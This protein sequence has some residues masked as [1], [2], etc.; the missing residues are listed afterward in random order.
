METAGLVIGVAGLAGLFTS[1]VEA[2]DKI[3]SYRTFGTDSHVLNTR[4][5][6]ARAR[7]E[8]W[9][10]GVGI[11][12]GRLKH[13]HHPALD[14]KAVSDAV[15]ELLHIIP[16]NRLGDTSGRVE[17]EKW[18]EFYGFWH[19]IVDSPTE[20]I[21]RERLAK[22]ELKYAKRYPRA[23]GYIKLYWLEP[24]KER[25]IKAWV[26]KYLHFGNVA[27]SRAEGIHSLI[28]SYIKT[29]TFD[30]FDSWQAMRHAV[31]NQLKELNH[32]RASQQIRTP[33]DISGGM[34][35]AVQGWV[36][37]QALRKVQEQR[38]LALASPQAPCMQPAGS[39]KT[40]QQYR[41]A[42]G[43]PLRYDKQSYEWCLDYK[44][45]SKR[46]I[47]STGSREWTKEEMMA[48]LDW[49]KAED[50]RIEAQVVKEMGKNPLANKRRGMTEIWRKAEM[51]SIEQETL[52]AAED[53]AELCIVVKRAVEVLLTSTRVDKASVDDD[54]RNAIS[55]ASGGGH[56]HV[57]VKLLD[58]GC[59]GVDTKDIDGW[60]PLAWAIQTD[61]SDTVRVLVNDEEVQLERRDGGGR[62]A[63][64]WAV[65][66]GH[67]KVVKVLLQAGADPEAKSNRGSTPISIAK[68]FGRD[69]LLSELMA[70]KA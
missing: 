32:I 49:S 12:Q 46:C 64:S 48:Y 69:D 28:K 61:S 3:Q 6:A 27:T 45:M 63:L 47:T 37:H 31:T 13:P 68:Q 56:H 1:C 60:T 7:F 4:F 52:Y 5:K 2:L 29:S 17:D 55:W 24:H 39:I 62:T 65:E 18:D 16:K 41:R 38:K 15:A 11:E 53:K 35:E 42:M 34:F 26:D 30:L 8:R 67:A 54:K 9:G 70:Y 19:T 14:D 44:Q 66:Y 43:L 59:P 21:F 40:N 10:P 33:L 57:L 22:F 51:D 20:E 23:V 25:I 50:E 36:S 58:G